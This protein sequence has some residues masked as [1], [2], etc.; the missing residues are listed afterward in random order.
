VVGVN[1]L[2]F[3]LFVA[4]VRALIW[5]TRR[6]AGYFCADLPEG[7]IYSLVGGKKEARKE[8]RKERM[9]GFPYTPRFRGI[10]Y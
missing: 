8:G 5:E 4:A 7:E 2:R 3:L 9:W 1:A 10:R 6:Q